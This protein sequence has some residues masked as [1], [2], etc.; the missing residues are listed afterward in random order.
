M[1]R[2]RIYRKTMRQIITG[3]LLFPVMLLLA[4]ALDDYHDLKQ[5]PWLWF[6]AL[7]ACVLIHLVRMIWLR[8]FQRCPHCGARA[9]TVSEEGVA[10]DPMDAQPYWARCRRCGVIMPTDM[11]RRA[12][13]NMIV[14]LRDGE[15]E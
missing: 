4:Y 7:I 15:G 5:V 2:F 14:P 3:F 8:H 11:G 13:G 6:A 1:E 9:I 10:A 12:M